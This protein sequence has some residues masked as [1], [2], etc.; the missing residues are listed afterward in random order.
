MVGKVVWFSA[1]KGFGFVQDTATQK[2][3]FCHFTSISMQG[4]KQLKEGQ[5]VEFDVEEGPKAGK[6]QTANVVPID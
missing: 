2:E 1:G 4:Y 3:Y 6:L 5:K